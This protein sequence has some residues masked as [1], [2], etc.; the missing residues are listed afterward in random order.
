MDLILFKS[1]AVG[2]YHSIRTIP[3]AIPCSLF[4]PIP[5]DVARESLGLPSNLPIILLGANNLLDY[6]K[7]FDLFLES[8]L[9]INFP[10]I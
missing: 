5:K 6:Y 4:K 9:H 1:S 2:S 10:L 8:L 3:N 7:G